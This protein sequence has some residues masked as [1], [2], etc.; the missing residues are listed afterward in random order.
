M[1]EQLNSTSSSDARKPDFLPSTIMEMFK[2]LT[3]RVIGL[4][5][6]AIAIAM[7]IA[8]VSYNK[9]DP[10]FN[11]TTT[12]AP[13]N[14]LGYYGAVFADL[15]L[16]SIGLAVIL[17][18][19]YIMILA[20]RFYY[21]HKPKKL[22]YHSAYLI[23]ATMFAAGFIQ[24]FL[25]PNTWPITAGFGGV[26][27]TILLDFVSASFVKII[28]LEIQSTQLLLVG[29]FGILAL[30][31]F[32][33]SLN[34][35]THE[36]KAVF[37]ITSRPFLYLAKKIKAGCIVCLRVSL[38]DPMQ[39]IVIKHKQQEH[40]TSNTTKADQDGPYH[41]QNEPKIHLDQQVDKPTIE[42][43]NIDE[44]S[45]KDAFRAQ[46]SKLAKKSLSTLYLQFIKRKQIKQARSV[47][48]FDHHANTTEDIL[49]LA[50]MVS[51]ALAR[52][53]PIA[54]RIH[55]NA[56][57][58]IQDI[59]LSQ[60]SSLNNACDDDK[61]SD[62]ANLQHA[63]LHHDSQC[64]DQEDQ[65]ASFDGS[66]HS[67]H[68]DDPKQS[69]HK[70]QS[71]DNA[72]DHAPANQATTPFLQAN[73][74]NSAK[75]EQTHTAKKAKEHDPQ[76]NSYAL[77]SVDL[78]TER[79]TENN[80]VQDEQALEQNARM[81]E[82]VLA[83]FGIYGQIINVR[84]GPVVTLYE[85]EPAP[86]TKTSRVIGLADDIARSMSAISVRIATVPGRSVIGIELPNETRE[87]VELKGLLA[88]KSFASDDNKLP[89]I[90]GKDIGGHPTIG[91]LATM[92]H[93]LIAG[94]TGSGKSVGLNA[95]ILSLL[96]KYTPQQCRFIMVD[97]KMLELSV[98]EGIPHL[99]TPV[100]TDP[101]KAA[102]ALKWAVREMENRYRSMA[103]MGVRNIEGYNKRVKQALATN[104]KLTRRVQTGF[105]NETGQPVHETQEIEPT[106][107]PFIIV[108]VDEMAD[109]ML[110]AGKEVEASV[111]RLAQMARA[112]GIHLV[113]AT[114]RPSV[115]VIT[116]TIKA[117]FPTRISFMV[118]SKI[119]S[120]TIL[121]EQGAEQLLGKGDMLYMAGGGRI[122]RVHAP[123]VEDNEVEA[124][125]NQ[126]RSQA[127]PEYIDTITDE[128]SLDNSAYPEQN[129]EGNNSSDELYDSAVAL[130]TRERKA[131]T[132]F[133]QRHLQIGY[134]RA[135]RIVEQMEKEGVISSA[136]RV[137]KRE[138]LA[139]DHA[140]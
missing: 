114:Q 59:H 126:L 139:G 57:P 110:V 86:G 100:V 98:Y 109:L 95:M 51:K 107:F 4:M 10:S 36:W 23:F 32:T 39:T 101:K 54:H 31:L 9:L 85:L 71:I 49:D 135:A 65:T 27:G 25:V 84:P 58:H 77:P 131:S 138:V 30:S 22:H 88:S 93:L 73:V 128:R 123:F 8:I 118:S 72:C 75:I 91:D 104:E 81:L 130:V 11:T 80:A 102:I 105:N 63:N 106:F 90:L 127:Q 42:N 6:G 97:P 74:D 29:I 43:K 18:I 117:N 129:S 133:V 41:Q 94:T 140:A 5:I 115:D 134:N 132:S 17:P 33:F 3:F 60:N 116:G 1:Q 24:Y 14:V 37:A 50:P 16:Q 83:D 92:P 34:L 70:Q 61:P 35:K 40:I 28:P 79:N 38:I 137:G 64:E 7:T 136:N 120:R 68:D 26:V 47:F 111:Q 62:V 44:P 48:L 96:Y 89:L 124:V 2:K 121:G 122:I 12:D 82:N 67:Q 112:A 56:A 103:A 113:T 45:I 69:F 46:A 15:L 87:I 78:L 55:A 52:H 20:Y 19:L 66:I 99:L 119:D 76:A 53:R 108:V 21:Q 13:T 125:C